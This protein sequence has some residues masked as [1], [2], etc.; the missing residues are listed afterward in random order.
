[1]V[2]TAKTYNT[3]SPN[4]KNCNDMR[5]TFG[6]SRVVEGADVLALP[7]HVESL[8]GNIHKGHHILPFVL[9]AKEEFVLGSERKSAT[10]ANE[11]NER[12]IAL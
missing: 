1:M 8:F 7:D 11:T 5:Y 3:P 6:S 12:H 10:F 2:S 4:E 9:F